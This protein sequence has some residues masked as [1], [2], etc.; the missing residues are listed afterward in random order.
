MKILQYLTI[1]SQILAIFIKTGRKT[2][3]IVINTA[4]T[5]IILY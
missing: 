1:M 2:A 3:D 4:V 5:P